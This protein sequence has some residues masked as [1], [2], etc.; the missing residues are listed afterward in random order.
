M[1]RSARYLTVAGAAFLTAGGLAFA[2]WSGTGPTDRKNGPPAARS[3]GVQWA[4][5]EDV[6]TSVGLDGPASPSWGAVFVDYDRNGWPDL[7]INRHK[8]HAWFMRNVEGRFTRDTSSPSFASPPEGRSYYD[9]HNCAWGEANG[10]G[11][12]DLYCVSGAQG[13]SG[14]G[15]NRLLLQNSEGELLQP[16]EPGPEDEFGRGRSVN[17]LDFDQ[18]GDLDIFVSN[19]IREGAPNALF[20]NHNGRYE[21]VTVGLEEERASVTSAWSDW[22][23]DGTPDLLV[24]GHGYLGTEAYENRN[25]LFR[26][27]DLSG[28]TGRTWRSA[29]FGDFDGDG[30]TDLHLVS[31]DSAVLFRNDH[32]GFRRI[33]RW[34]LQFGRM[35]HWFDVDNDGDLDLFVVQGTGGD[36]RPETRNFPDLVFV[37]E[38]SGFQMVQQ[39]GAEGPPRGSGDAATVAD[40]DRDG[41]LDVFVSNGYLEGPGRWT[42]LR[43]VSQVGNWAGLQ[44]FGTDQN[45]MGIGARI[46]VA[47]PGEGSYWRELNDGVVGNVQSE[48]GYVHLGLG[49]AA[50]ASIRIHWPDGT[51]DCFHVQAGEIADIGIGTHTCGNGG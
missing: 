24:L 9:R 13:G 38:S 41:R 34:D 39:S 33:E 19:E 45:P 40:Y 28:I 32:G 10:D 37:Q 51:R 14:T 42:L 8:R 49:Q 7:L 16:N 46:E 15:P 3:P 30:W 47:P 44:L 23:N 25:G 12:F 21:R 50:G 6:T 18:D 36:P 48:V 4:M 43:N 11:Q 1:T 5:F 22:N 17:W 2:L 27:V 31:E 35:S 26:A 29:A 20:E